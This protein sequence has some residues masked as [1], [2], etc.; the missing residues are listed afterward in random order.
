[1]VV[2]SG[3][4]DRTEEVARR[5]TDRFFRR[6]WD[7]YGKQKQ[8]ALDRATGEWVLSIDAD[9]VVTPELRASI[10]QALRDPG[11]WVGFRMELHTWFLDRWFGGRGWRRQWKMRL[12]R[13]GGARFS[14]NRVHEGVVVDGPIGRLSGVLLHYHYR[15]MAHEVQKV[16]FYSTLAAQQLRA[17]GKRS[18]PAAPVFR[19]AAHFGKTYLLQGGFLYGRAGFVEAAL[20]GLYGFLKYAK[21]WD[22]PRR[23]LEETRS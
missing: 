10:E 20:N 7:G 13:R 22:A 3:S 9:E 14:E 1:V 11:E 6:E 5:F 12:F 4:T 8:N 21:L 2:D 18:G 16:N 19:G 17:A 23:D 15:D